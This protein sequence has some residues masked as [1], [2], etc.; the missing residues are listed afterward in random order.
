MS[1]RMAVAASLPSSQAWAHPA[2]PFRDQCLRLMDV[3]RPTGETLIVT[4]HGRPAAALESREGFH[5]DPAA[6]LIAATT[7]VA[8]RQ[9]VTSDRKI[10]HGATRRTEPSCLD[11]R[12]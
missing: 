9:L 1:S 4:R 7:I 12:T 10:L 6:Q 3:V 5:A 11:V 8:R 2:A